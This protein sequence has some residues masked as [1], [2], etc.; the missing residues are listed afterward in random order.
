[1]AINATA[2]TLTA[3]ADRIGTEQ[4]TTT[5]G[6]SG[7]TGFG[8]LEDTVRLAAALRLALSARG[9]PE[10]T[11]RDMGPPARHMVA[12]ARCTQGASKSRRAHWSISWTHSSLRS[13]LIGQAARFNRTRTTL[14][15]RSTSRR[16]TG[17]TRHSAPRPQ[18]RSRTTRR[19]QDHR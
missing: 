2:R 5:R 9:I 16:R 8:F 19:S 7:G 6:R 10:L 18:A 14:G 13:A 15:S 4:S 1:M 3:L 12:P 11:A 17:G